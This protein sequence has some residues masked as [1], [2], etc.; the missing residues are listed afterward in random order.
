VD[1]VKSLKAALK[2]SRS[3]CGIAIFDSLPDSIVS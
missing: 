2:K 1:E 3:G